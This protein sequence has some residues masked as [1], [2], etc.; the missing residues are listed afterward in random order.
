MSPQQVQQ[1]QL[2][3]LRQCSVAAKT[4]QQGSTTHSYPK[5][6]GRAILDRAGQ[7]RSYLLCRWEQ[8]KARN[9]WSGQGIARLYELE[10]KIYF[11]S[12][13]SNLAIA[14]PTAPLHLHWH[15]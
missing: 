15:H 13:P 1:E 14:P 10:R 8:R 6:V 3:S 4:R 11:H 2:L 7:M 9:R 12:A 5:A